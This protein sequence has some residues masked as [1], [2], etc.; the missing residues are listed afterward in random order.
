MRENNKTLLLVCPNS[1]CDNT[2][3][4]KH[5]SI[6]RG[7]WNSNV[8]RRDKNNEEGYIFLSRHELLSFY[9][10]DIRGVKKTQNVVQ[11]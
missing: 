8:L 2:K 5:H 6:I 10:L 7:D 11:T 9:P 4:T 1:V 3:V